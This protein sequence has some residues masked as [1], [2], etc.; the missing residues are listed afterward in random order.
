MQYYWL[1]QYRMFN[2]QLRDFGIPPIVGYLLLLG[3]FV[4]L[5]WLVFQRIMYAPYAYALLALA[6]LAPLHQSGR[7]RF[8]QNCFGPRRYRL[9]RLAENGLAALPF[10]LFLVYKTCYWQAL[11][12]GCLAPAL[13]WVRL[14][15]GSLPAWPTPFRRQPFES[16]MGFRRNIGLLA[17]CYAFAGIAVAVDNP[18]L[19]MAALLGLFIICMLFYQYTEPIFYVWVFALSPTQFLWHKTKRALWHTTLLCLPAAL[20]LVIA[21]TGQC[22]ALVGLFVLGLLYVAT[23]ISAKYAVF[24]HTMNLPQIVLLTLGLSLP[25][26]LVVLLPYFYIQS[27]QKL[28]PVLS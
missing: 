3:G 7:N 23:M 17:A 27:L 8:L 22:W 25:P 28:K 20:L 16:I 14:G 5:S 21:F 1:L 24:P 18:N 2:R 11:A 26:L 4:L 10:L 15:N 12:L 9:L 19:G 13:S 6:L